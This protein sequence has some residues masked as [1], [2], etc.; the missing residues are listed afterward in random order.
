MTLVSTLDS[1]QLGVEALARE[2]FPLADVRVTRF[3]EADVDCYR[4]TITVS[5]NLYTN[6]SIQIISRASVPNQELHE[7]DPGRGL[8]QDQDRGR[9]QDRYQEDLARLKMTL[10]APVH[11]LFHPYTPEARQP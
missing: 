1:L 7:L 11:Q 6:N 5:F 8:D 10:Y 2:D 9:D 4:F 3:Y